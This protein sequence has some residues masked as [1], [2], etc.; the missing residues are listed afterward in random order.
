[1]TLSYCSTEQHL[2]EERSLNY[3]KFI[4]TCVLKI[5]GQHRYHA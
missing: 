5:Q 4:G 1:M 2:K 3:F